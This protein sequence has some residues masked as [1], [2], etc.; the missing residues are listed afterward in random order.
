MQTENIP[1]GKVL[2]PITTRL[3]FSRDVR[4]LNRLDLK[5]N[6]L[7]QIINKQNRFLDQ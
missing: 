5:Y 4:T 7:P 6:D 1:P 2:R 3:L